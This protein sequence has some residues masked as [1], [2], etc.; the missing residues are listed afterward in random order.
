MF[1]RSENPQVWFTDINNYMLSILR[2]KTQKV[3]GEGRGQVSVAW[4]TSRKQ[5]SLRQH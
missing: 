2:N 4:L 3:R 1:Q 5:D